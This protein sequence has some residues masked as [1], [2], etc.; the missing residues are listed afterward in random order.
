VFALHEKVL[1]GEVLNDLDIVF[2]DNVYA[3]T[4]RC[5][6]FCKDHHEYD[7]LFSRVTHFY[8]EITTIALENE[9]KLR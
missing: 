8:H 6:A 4:K 9:S 3:E 1:Q 7:D 2:L 5:H